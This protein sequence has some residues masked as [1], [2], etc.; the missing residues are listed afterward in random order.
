MYVSY[1]GGA[2]DDYNLTIHVWKCGDKNVVS[3]NLEHKVCRFTP[4]TMHINTDK[5]QKWTRDATN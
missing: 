2:F 1:P 4:M 3:E 5:D